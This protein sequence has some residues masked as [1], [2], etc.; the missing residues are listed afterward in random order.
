MKKSQYR[1]IR[2]FR[3]RGNTAIDSDKQLPAISYINFD[4][5][6]PLYLFSAFF[7]ELNLLVICKLPPYLTSYFVA[8]PPGFIYREEAYIRYIIAVVVY[9]DS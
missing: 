1:Y 9:R 8:I 4:A 2:I 6:I 3:H 7:Y 5:F